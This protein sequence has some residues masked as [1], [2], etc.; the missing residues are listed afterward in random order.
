MVIARALKMAAIHILPRRMRSYICLSF[1]LDVIGCLQVPVKYT[2]RDSSGK[3]SAVE[4]KASSNANVAQ[5]KEMAESF[6]RNRRNANE[7]IQILSLCE[8]RFAKDLTLP[9]YRL[10]H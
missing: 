4:L 2:C 8:V 6:L 1:T 5:V 7:L 10:F 3:M 9:L